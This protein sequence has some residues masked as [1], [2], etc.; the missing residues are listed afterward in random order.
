MN[1]DL[2]MSQTMTDVLFTG[3]E[4]AV[5]GILACVFFKN[6]ARVIHSFTGFGIGYA[7]T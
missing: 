2:K 4:G 6:K 7:L 1:S 5:V 3:A